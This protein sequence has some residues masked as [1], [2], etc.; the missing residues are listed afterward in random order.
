MMRRSVTR[1]LRLTGMIFLVSILA[2][3]C[4]S[5]PSPLQLAEAEAVHRFDE[6]RLPYGQR[7]ALAKAGYTTRLYGLNP[8]FG[9]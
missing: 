6:S 7:I 9:R 8:Y 2:T 5:T 3:A 4:T 1:E